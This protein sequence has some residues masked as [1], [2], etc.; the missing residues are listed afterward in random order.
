MKKLKTKHKSVSEHLVGIDGRVIA[1]T[2]LLDISSSDVRLIRIHGMGVSVKRLLPR[3]FST[4]SSHSGKC[5][6]FLKDV[7]A[8][9][10]RFDGLVEL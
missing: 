5:C 8:K 6:C 4:D 9:S 2:Q 3:S 1:I 10:S 7:R